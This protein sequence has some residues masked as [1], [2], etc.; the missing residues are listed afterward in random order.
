MMM[1]T[2]Q[3]RAASIPDDVSLLQQ[4]VLEGVV[5]GTPPQDYDD[6]YCIAYAK[7]HDGYLVTNDLYRFRYCMLSRSCVIT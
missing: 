3:V 2:D 7:Q 4:L 5:I 1:D 6:S